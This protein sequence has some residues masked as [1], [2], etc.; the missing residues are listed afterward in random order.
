[1]A[2]LLRP[3]AFRSVKLTYV[4]LCSGDLSTN[5][6]KSN[7][8]GK[9]RTHHFLAQGRE[10]NRLKSLCFHRH[11]CHN[12][13]LLV[14]VCGVRW[15][16]T[17]TPSSATPS[18]AVGDVPAGYIPEPPPLPEPV[19]IADCL[20]AL[21]EPTL[22]S[23][24]LAGMW[25][26]GLVQSSLEMLHV[27]A[28][29][30]WWG[31]I[32]VFTVFLRLCMFPL[33][34]K[35]QRN[36]ANL[37]NHM[38]TMARL[39]D[40]FSKARMSG[41]TLEAARAGEELMSFMKRNEIKPFKNFLV[42]LAQLPV[43]VS[44][45]VGLRQMANLPVESM[46]TGGMFWFTDL[47]VADPFYALPLLTMATFLLTV[48]VGVDGVKANTMTHGMKWFMRAMPVFI[49]PFISNFPM[50]MLCYWMTSNTF[51]LIQVLFLKIP[52]VRTFFEIPEIVKHEPS[53]VPKKKGFVEGFRSSMNNA[54]LMNEMEDRERVDAIRFREAGLGPL[55]KT[56]K[57]D[58]TKVQQQT[59]TKAISAKSKS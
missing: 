35:S 52:T 47:T 34:I 11:K 6:F 38:P 37:S 16:S 25:P 57:Y 41:N 18:S 55:Q 43:F 23:L 40:R 48:E 33:V 36:A 32:A 1:M 17:Q 45:F 39:Q 30:P 2:G 5:F 13:R 19:E 59:P 22:Q 10:R 14:A 8:T 3:H 44:M 9:C 53:T 58:P 51:S 28:G 12:D 27:S 24:G 50:A 56:Y 15:N 42:P 7:F 20:N 46:K 49:F 54:K 31:S 29:L 21:G 26:S 4:H